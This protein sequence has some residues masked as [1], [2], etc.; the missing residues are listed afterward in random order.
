MSHK[1]IFL[2]TDRPKFLCE[3]LLKDADEADKVKTMTLTA[4]GNLKS[5]QKSFASSSIISTDTSTLHKLSNLKDSFQSQPVSK[6]LLRSSI[7]E[8]EVVE[9]DNDFG[10]ILD[11]VNQG[12]SAEQYSSIQANGDQSYKPEGIQASRGKPRQSRLSSSLRSSSIAEDGVDLNDS[13]LSE[14]FGASFASSDNEKSDPK[15]R[16]SR[17][18]AGRRHSVLKGV[19]KLKK[20][21]TRGSSSAEEVYDIDKSKRRTS[22]AILGAYSNMEKAAKEKQAASQGHGRKHNIDSVIHDMIKEKRVD[23]RAVETFHKMDVN[24]NGCIEFQEFVIAYRKLNPYVSMVQLQAMFDEADLDANGT[25][26]LQEVSLFLSILLHPCKDDST[27][28]LLFLVQFI[29][30]SKMPNVEVLGKLSVINRDDRG[31]VQVMPSQEAYFGEELEKSA[32][33]GVG[34]FLM[35]ESQSLSMQLYESRIASMQRFVAMTVMF[36]QIGSRVQSFFPKISF[37][38]LGYRMDRTHSIMRIATTASPVS[39]ADVRERMVDLHLRFKIQR[40]VNLVSRKYREWRS[41]RDSPRVRSTSPTVASL[42]EDE[43]EVETTATAISKKLTTSDSGRIL[44]RANTPDEY[45]IPP[46]RPSTSSPQNYYEMRRR[47]SIESIG[48]VG[49]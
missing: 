44:F 34:S 6:S 35:S 1:A 13:S 47:S 49:S 42:S 29:K 31:L 20:S 38:V 3:K 4:T 9:E 37:G 32:P 21:I 19:G 8:D 22:A 5:E 27:D 39:G 16:R 17:Q 45:N 30:M 40:A 10:R 25:L 26:D 48:S 43:D 15:M 2:E 28:A 36:H 14:D 41:Q 18:R 23:E 7:V 11:A 33:K 12:K 46:R 24:G